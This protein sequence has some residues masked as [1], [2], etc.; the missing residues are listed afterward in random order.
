MAVNP[1]YHHDE[2]VLR[3]QVPSFQALQAEQQRADGAEDPPEDVIIHCGWGRL[4]LAHTFSDPANLAKSLTNESTGDRDIAIY[5]S[6]PHVV[7]SMA[8]QALFLDPSDTLRLWMSQYRPRTQALPGVTVRRASSSQDIEAINAIFHQRKMVPVPSEHVINRRRSK[9]VVY[10]VAEE[11][12][13]GKVIGTVMGVNHVRAF[14]DPHKGSSLW[15]LAVSPDGKTPGVGEALVRYLAEYFQAR[16]CQHMDLSVLHNNY[17]AK[18]LYEKL[19]FQNVKTFSL[20]KK[21]AINE[22]LYVGPE[23]GRKLNPYAQ[24][25]VDE[26]MRRGI[27]VTV[28]DDENNLFTLSFG[29]RHIRCH[30]SLSELT[31]AFAMTLCQNKLLTHRT[32]GREGLRTPCHQLYQDQANAEAF[33]Q[34]HGAVVVKPLDS[35]Q[36]QGISVDIRTPEALHAAI[37]NAQQVSAKVLLETYHQGMDLRVVV[38]GY[39]MV[40][41]AIRRPAE[42]YG[43]GRDNLRTLIQKQSRRRAAATGGESRIPM[44]QETERCLHNGGYGWEDI[45]PAGEHLVV[46]KTANLHT[47]GTLVD[48]TDALHPGLRKA[49]E[50]AA[51]ALEIPVV[52]MD[53]MVPDH[54]QPEYVI[55]EANERPGLENHAPQPTAE[56]F[57]DLLFPLTRPHPN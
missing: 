36:G 31:T 20:K 28:D 37:A 21:N 39:K 19:G 50:Q 33:L 45:L 44:D 49:A 2:R 11:L 40:A 17:E 43:N 46:R 29:G 55:I 22:K 41:A 47:G 27:E 10:L 25:I 8:P 7:L 13:S 53:F 23:T 51:Q 9:E 57:I 12:T 52:G 16:G 48:V 14:N 30:E 6:N 24:I 34:E 38:I 35:E 42:V 18:A 54:T 56:A 1:R 26:A 5:V 3:N 15:C 4:L 32:C